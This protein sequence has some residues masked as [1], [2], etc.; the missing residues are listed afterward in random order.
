MI[1]V[2][3]HIPFC[4]TRCPYCDFLSQPTPGAVPTAFAD[5]LVHEI[6]A[7]DGPVDARTVFFGGGTPSLLTPES[8]TRILET[9]RRRFRL[10]QPEI[11]L[12]AN[13]DDVTATLA[14]AW[15]DL[16][17]NRV[18]LGVQSFDDAV[19]RYLGRRHDAAIAHRACD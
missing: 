4:R 1:G 14:D 3:V 15:R 18:S 7:Y 19:L 12:E 13:P 10:E 5:A 9:L 6:D 17:I 8:L 11:S 16:G 2:Y